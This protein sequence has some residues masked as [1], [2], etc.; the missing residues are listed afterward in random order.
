[1]ALSCEQSGGGERCEHDGQRSAEGVRLGDAAQDADASVSEV[2]DGED[3]H[4][5]HAGPEKV[6]CCKVGL[7]NDRGGDVGY[8]L[9][10]RCN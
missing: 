5:G 4:V 8:Y 3:E 1:M 7:V 2:D 9:R 10:E 6:A